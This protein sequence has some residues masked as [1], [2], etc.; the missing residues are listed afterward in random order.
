MGCAISKSTYVFTIPQNLLNYLL[1]DVTH[2]S[3]VD[4][5]QACIHYIAAQN[6]RSKATAEVWLKALDFAGKF[7]IFLYKNNFPF[8][9]L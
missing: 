3:L 6:N 8:Q 2:Q 1:L 7:I 9:V 4:S 5:L